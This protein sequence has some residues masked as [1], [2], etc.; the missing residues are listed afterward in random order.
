M[1]LSAKR[2]WEPVGD[3]EK[4]SERDLTILRDIGLVR[5]LTGRHVQ[6]LHFRDGSP[7][8]QARRSRSVLQR[9]S[10]QGWL[11]RLERRIGGVHAGSSGLTYS[12]SAKGQRL[13]TRRGPAGGKRLRRPWEPSIQFS[14][15]VL[16]G[17][18]LYVRLREREADGAIAGLLFE[19]EPAAWRYW[20]G[21]GSERLVVKPDASVSFQTADFDY[22]LFVEVDRGTQ[23]RAVIRNKGRIYAE[24]FGSGTE[25]DRIGYF[26][27]VLFVT[28][29]Q[30]RREV[31]VDAL[32]GLEAKS[33]RLFQV[34]TMDEAFTPDWGPP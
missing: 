16:A 31:I 22:A 28:T 26:P 9:L 32:S 11:V 23:S 7:L 25:Q 5:L 19:S 29:N 3:G 30:E 21:L 12:L 15:H 20:T 2:G 27:Q 33:W 14:D 1:T 8:T 6:R 13:V 24:F 4:L 18:E 10:D 17:S 34:L